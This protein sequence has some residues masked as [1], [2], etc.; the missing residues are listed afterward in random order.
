MSRGQ[1]VKNHTKIENQLK[2]DTGKYQYLLFI[3]TPLNTLSFTKHTP[4]RRST[5]YF[6]SRKENTN[7]DLAYWHISLFTYQDF[8]T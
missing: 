7:L 2:Q 8:R 5:L 3:S 6:T 4:T 1:M